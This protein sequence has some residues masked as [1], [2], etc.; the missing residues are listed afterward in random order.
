MAAVAVGLAFA[1]DRAR[2][3]VVP[4]WSRWAQVALPLGAILLA[5][6]L[7]EELG[8][9]GYPLRRLADAIGR[10]P[11]IVV[12]AAPFALLHV[13]NPNATLF[14]TINVALAA[15]WLS[16]AFFSYGGMGLAWGLHFG[17]NAG[18]ALLFDAP[19]SGYTFQVPAVDYT[20]GPRPWVDGGA[21]G[22]E[23]GIVA[24]IVVIAG[25][26]ALLGARFKRPREWLVG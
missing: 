16:F 17:W 12:L 8:F 25:T 6:A 23:G 2:V 20:P 24:T 9:R 7:A 14:S 21:F 26:L 22:P 13:G 10:A 3:S 18:L 15:V 5:A 1:G 4:E 11:A 19:V